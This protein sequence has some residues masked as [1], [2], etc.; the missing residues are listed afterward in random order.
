MKRQEK[1]K[2]SQVLHFSAPIPKPKSHFTTVKSKRKLFIIRHQIIYGLLIFLGGVVVGLAIATWLLTQSCLPKPVGTIL[3]HHSC[4]LRQFMPR[5]L[6]PPAWQLLPQKG[7]EA[8]EFGFRQVGKLPP[9][10][11]C[12]TFC[13]VSSVTALKC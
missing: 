6:T 7:I 9:Y 11:P 12:P 10:H 3:R 5:L 13:K 2:T 1:G 8:R 4:S